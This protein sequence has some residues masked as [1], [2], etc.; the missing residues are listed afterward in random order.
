MKVKKFSN[1]IAYF[2]GKIT[3]NEKE[4]QE[5]C[6]AVHAIFIEMVDYVRYWITY[7]RTHPADCFISNT[8]HDPNAHIITVDHGEE[9]FIYHI[10]DLMFAG[11]GNI[12]NLLSGGLAQLL[13]P[14]NRKYFD[15]LKTDPSLA[16][17]IV[18]EMVR[19]IS[20]T[21]RLSRVVLSNQKIE[22]HNIKKGDAICI[23]LLKAN[24]DPKVFENPD[25][26]DIRRVKGDLKHLAFG[27]GGHLCIG[28]NLARLEARV[29]LCTIVERLPN[30]KLESI[31]FGSNA[32]FRMVEKLNLTF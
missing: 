9:L 4:L 20:P 8:L 17:D 11:H 5:K 12:S 6:E 16:P 3:T 18:E 25:Q 13:L 30:L 21:H 22:G 10:I 19:L 28:R 15:L 7:Y 24:Y 32:T 23:N 14:Q 1:A 27:H 31:D 26:M 2:I 29:M